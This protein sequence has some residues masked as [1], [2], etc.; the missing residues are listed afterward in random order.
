MAGTL[1]G[2]NLK[3][4]SVVLL[5]CILNKR[6]W[7]FQRI[8]TR[9]S[10]VDGNTE[11]GL[12]VRG[13][14]SFHGDGIE[15]AGLWLAFNHRN[16]SSGPRRQPSCPRH[17]DRGADKKPAGQLGDPMAFS[18]LNQIANRG[19]RAAKS[20][21]CHRLLAEK[22]GGIQ[23]AVYTEIHTRSIYIC[24]AAEEAE[25]GLTEFEA[26]WDKEHLPIGQSWRRNWTR[27]TQIFRL[28]TRD[29]Y[30][31]LCNQRNRVGEYGA[32]KTNQAPRRTSERRSSHQTALPR[33]AQHQ[34]KMD[35]A[36][37]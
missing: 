16:S 12:P 32:A 11:S 17:M 2:L 4:P 7:C 5:P 25:Q 31:Y 24:A 37:P 34:K 22:N 28:S 35:L 29:P 27:L 1:G 19:R 14:V 30:G 26:R 9:H 33:I 15:V 8:A 18:E 10:A 36:H 3:V 6:T 23:G 13:V 21:R 20:R